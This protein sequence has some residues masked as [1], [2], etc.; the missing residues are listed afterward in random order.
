MAH[1]MIA[2]CLFEALNVNPASQPNKESNS[3]MRKKKSTDELQISEKEATKT[4]YEY[5][6]QFG[7]AYVVTTVRNSCVSLRG[8][9]KLRTST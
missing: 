6:S 1:L 2:H 8:G 3:N 4:F 7:P 5:A 9:A